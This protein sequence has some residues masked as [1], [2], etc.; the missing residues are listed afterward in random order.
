MD[1]GD[2]LIAGVAVVIPGRTAPARVS[3]VS[4]DLSPTVAIGVLI[5]FEAIQILISHQSNPWR[6]A[7]CAP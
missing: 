3:Y 5:V 1:H 7:R 2:D 6:S 4:Q